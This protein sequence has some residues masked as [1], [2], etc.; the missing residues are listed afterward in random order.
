MEPK[1]YYII[2]ASLIFA[3]LAW[4]SVN[5]REEYTI[6]KVLPVTIE[7]LKAGTALKYPVPKNVAVRFRGKGLALAGLYLV[8]QVQYY[9]N[10]SSVSHEDFY[11][12][13]ANLLEH[14]TLP[15]ALQSIDVNPD[16]II[17]ALDEFYEK[18]VSVAPR[19]ILSYREGYGQVGPIR[20]SPDSI[21]ISGSR[22]A[23]ATINSWPTAYKKFD[24]IRSPIDYMLPLEESEYY[25]V[26]LTR[27]SARLQIDA[28][29]F[30]E[31][32]FT[33]IPVHVT[34]VP[35]SREVV[36]IPP[37][38]DII[39]RGGIEQLAKLRESDF[40]LSM[41][42]ELLPQD[43]VAFVTPI[44]TSPPDIKVVNKKPEQFQF[45]IRKKL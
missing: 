16:T 40:Q 15:A 22:T 3:L 4:F 20:L 9:I 39:V 14:V 5:L 21:F 25:S 37:K 12:T 41:N 42:Y 10:V 17:L 2:I 13:K 1:R 45:I 38:M 7:N 24:D 26:E 11:L 43:S 18:K 23:L 6:V 27:R 33:G 8:P 28:Q 19:I 36:F 35:L 32:T 34:G 30:A 29:P 44:L 31:K